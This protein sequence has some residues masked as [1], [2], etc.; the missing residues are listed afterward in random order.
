MKLL[1]I[2]ILILGTLLTAITASYSGQDVGFQIANISGDQLTVGPISNGECLHNCKSGDKSFQFKSET[3]SPECFET[4]TIAK[5]QNSPFVFVEANSSFFGCITTP[6]SFDVP[7]TTNLGKKFT[8]S[9]I[10]N[11][12]KDWQPILPQGFT[13]ETDSKCWNQ[14]TPTNTKCFKITVPANLNTIDN[15]KQSSK[16]T[17]H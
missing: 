15:T 17:S 5:G 4:F 1:N 9:F 2:K 8:L 3:S 13:A 16:N 11:L 6:S 10:K 7:I 12:N 14:K